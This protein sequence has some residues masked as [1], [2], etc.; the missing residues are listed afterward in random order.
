[1]D[2]LNISDASITASSERNANHAAKRV[3]INRYLD[4]A[5]A[6]AAA[7]DD[8]RPWIQFDMEQKVTVWGVVV[9][10]RCDEP[11]TNQRVTV[12]TVAVS[13]DIVRWTDVSDVQTLVYLNS[14]RYN[15]T[16]W[17]DDAVTARYWRIYILDWE[18]QASMKADLIGLPIGKPWYLLWVCLFSYEFPVCSHETCTVSYKLGQLSL[19]KSLS[20]QQLVK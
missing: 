14:F 6:W 11:Y 3:R 5:C 13:E 17:F 1:M 9:N 10:P 12:L 16:S 20:T 8:Y 7:P 18:N 19:S 15:S 4:Y 2:Y